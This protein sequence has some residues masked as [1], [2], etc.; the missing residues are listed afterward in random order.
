MTKRKQIYIAGPLFSEHERKFLEEI[1]EKVAANLGLDPQRDI[2][3]P[4]RDAGNIGI[5]GERRDEVFS[6]D[7]RF[8]DDASVVVALL[9]GPDIDSGTAV[10]LG[11]AFASNKQ[12]FGILTDWRHWSPDRQRVE[13]INTMIWG[14]CGR[15]KRIF[16]RIDNK[17]V[18]DL[19]RVLLMNE[20][21]DRS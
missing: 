2:F 10:E 5:H 9:D 13:N 3:L 19:K 14:V 18:R 12:I 21:I 11:Y 1:A 6:C 4:H 8:L 17:F 20:R 7:L 16:Q 15:G